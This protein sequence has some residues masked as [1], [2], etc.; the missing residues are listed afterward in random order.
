MWLRNNP[1]ESL[2]DSSKPMREFLIEL[3]KKLERNEVEDEKLVFFFRNS[4]LV[5]DNPRT[6]ML[7]S[8]FTEREFNPSAV[9]FINIISCSCGC[10]PIV[11]PCN[12]LGPGSK[13]LPEFTV[14]GEFTKS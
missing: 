13:D 6:Q 3:G 5:F 1:Y 9:K 4:K 12:Q 2:G 10:G 7:S 14:Q 11:E 8:D